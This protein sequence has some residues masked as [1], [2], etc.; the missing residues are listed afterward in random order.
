MAIH[1]FQ[2][3]LLAGTFTLFLGAL[4][5]DIAYWS[6]YHV[7]WTNFASWLIAG[8]LV[9]GGF[10]LLI[11]VVGLRHPARRRGRHL[12]Y[13]L[14]LLAMWLLG[15]ID[16][17]VHARDAWAAMPEGLML[18]VIVSLLAAAATWLGFSLLHT[19]ELP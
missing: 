17:L 8:G 9:S 3:F 15:L 5:N 19:R 6:T 10:A 11:A 14:L 4:L 13:F 7:Q 12:V 1:P 18:S 2:A 16:A